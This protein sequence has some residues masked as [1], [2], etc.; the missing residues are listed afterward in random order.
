[1]PASGQHCQCTRLCVCVFRES[2]SVF[3]VHVGVSTLVV[4]SHRHWHWQLHTQL[5][6]KRH[7]ELERA[8]RALLQGA[9]E[10]TDQHEGKRHT[11][12]QQWGRGGE[13]KRR[14]PHTAT[15]NMHQHDEE[16]GAVGDKKT[17]I[18]GMGGIRMEGKLHEWRRGGYTCE[19]GGAGEGESSM[20]HAA[21]PDTR[22]SH[23]AR[24]TEHTDKTH[25]P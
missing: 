18:K 3:S 11:P 15:H 9:R 19:W 25:L 10:R 21:P 1:M 2:A 5:T 6:S 7:G 23:P 16:K 8:R 22:R 14:G 12:A 24:H 17:P 4:F 13:G 20:A